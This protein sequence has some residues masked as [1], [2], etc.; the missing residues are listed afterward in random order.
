[1]P[2]GWTKIK[3]AAEYS[4]VSPRTIRSWLKAGL[5]HARLPSGTILI[6]YAAI[7][8]FLKQF[9]DRQFDVDAVVDELCKEM[10]KTDMS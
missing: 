9:A 3:G 7:D 2:N 4:G 6:Q 1:M 5:M 10:T 8:A